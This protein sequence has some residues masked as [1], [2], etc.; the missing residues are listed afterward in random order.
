[1]SCAPSL[2]SHPSS[3]RARA[4]GHESTMARQYVVFVIGLFSGLLLAGTVL[5]LLALTTVS[6]GWQTVEMNEL[7]GDRAQLSRA[8]HARNPEECVVEQQRAEEEREKAENERMERMR[9]EK[10]G[11]ERERA[12][13]ERMQE[14]MRE[15]QEREVVAGIAV[16]ENVEGE[17][18]MF[19]RTRRFPFFVSDVLAD[20]QRFPEADEESCAHEDP[21]SVW[22]LGVMKGGSSSLWKWMAEEFRGAL[23]T[24]WKSGKRWKEVRDFENRAIKTAAHAAAYTNKFEKPK[25][26]VKC[27]R[28]TEGTPDYLRMPDCRT[29]LMAYVKLA[30]VEDPLFVITV[31]HPVTR[32]L[33]HANFGGKQHDY[34]LVCRQYD[35]DEEW[36]CLRRL[37]KLPQK[38]T[39]SDFIDV[40][41]VMAGARS[42]CLAGGSKCQA[43][44]DPFWGSQYGAQVV[45]WL[46][47]LDPA[48]FLFVVQEEDQPH[49][50]ADPDTREKLQDRLSHALSRFM[51]LPQPPPPSKPYSADK[52]TDHNYKVFGKIEPEDIERGMKVF[53]QDM[54]LF[55][56]I[57]GRRIWS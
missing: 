47:T 57:V 3:M 10:E 55:Y 19:N 42:F 45:E 30:E 23:R 37:R 32:A 36:G 33:S 9:A 20:P 17:H 41:E 52:F 29:N 46:Q 15:E 56:S 7:R 8:E 49:A 26:A 50:R 40:L 43:R 25:E 12:E 27:H 1:M 51:R 38:G 6:P 54:E 2:L 18:P 24:A 34:E 28:A 44:S 14:R 22:V 31:R 21:V 53:E 11:R 13:H 39:A 48:R 16:H 4:H 5:N 35:P